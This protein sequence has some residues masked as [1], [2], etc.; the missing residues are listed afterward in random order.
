[1]RWP[2]R[3][4]SRPNTQ[5][6]SEEAAEWAFTVCQSCS[7]LSRSPVKTLDSQTSAGIRC[8]RCARPL[9]VERNSGRV[10]DFQGEKNRFEIHKTKRERKKVQ[11]FFIQTARAAGAESTS[12]CTNPSPNYLHGG[13]LLYEAS[14][15]S[16]DS[17]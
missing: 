12:Q 4:V 8:P 6:P 10:V 3:A 11:E 14:S 5:L 9:R 17:S 7:Q 15:G 13:R 16:S 2:S 1:M